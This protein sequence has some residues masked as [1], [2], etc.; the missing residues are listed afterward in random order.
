MRLAL[1]GD[2]HFFQLL[3]RPLDLLGKRL[4]GT[5]HL[6]TTRRRKFHQDLLEPIITKVASIQADLV[7]FSGDLTTTS[8]DSEFKRA[9]AIIRPLER[10]TALLIVPGNHDRYTWRSARIRRVEEQLL[11][12]MPGHF[13]HFQKISDGWHLLAL[14]SARPRW[15][16]A[17]G[18]IGLEQLEA[19]RRH[20]DTL[21]QDDGLIVLCHY[22]LS[23][24][25]Q[26]RPRPGHD[27]EDQAALRELLTQCKARTFYLHGHVHRPWFWPL[28]DPAMAHITDINAGSPTMI[29][30]AHPFGQGFWQIDLPQV[31]GQPP[32]LCRHVPTSHGATADGPDWKV[33]HVL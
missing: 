15:I 10:T 3:P 31:R 6:W 30:A 12:L 28:T 16:T 27:L 19:A 2:I 1:V 24:P 11:G 26:V 14:D 25:T 20:L 23:L 21:T 8:L 9:L 32:T 18:R 33:V 5:L 22:P 4:L 13:P 17:V 7:L 29:D